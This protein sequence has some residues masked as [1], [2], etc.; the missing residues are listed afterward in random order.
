MRFTD[1]SVMVA[2]ETEFINVFRLRANDKFW[3]NLECIQTC[4]KCKMGLGK[5]IFI[6][7][8]IQ[9]KN[10][11]ALETEITYNFKK[12]GKEYE[13]AIQQIADREMRQLTVSE[14]SREIEERLR[15]N[16]PKDYC[17]RMCLKMCYFIQKIH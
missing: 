10:T 9:I 3:K 16:K 8:K 11:E 13:H 2:N 5:H 7:F 12:I 1:T 6:P 14:W 17:Q 4:V 15:V